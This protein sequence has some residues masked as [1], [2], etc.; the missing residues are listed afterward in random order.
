MKKNEPFYTNV[1]VQGNQVYHFYI[2]ENGKRKKEQVRFEPTLAVRTNTKT[3]Y[4]DIHGNYLQ[5]KTFGNNMQMWGWKKKKQDYEEIF[6]DIGVPYEF[7][8]RTYPNDIGVPDLS[9]LKIFNIDIETDSGINGEFPSA[10]EAKYHI[11]LITIHD[12]N[13]DKFYTFGHTFDYTP[14]DKRVVYWKYDNEREMM[15][16]FLH[17]F[18]KQRPDVVTGW[19]IEGYD[20]PYIVNRIEHILPENE[21]P[22]LLSPVNELEEFKT[23]MNNQS[24][25]IKGIAIMDYMKAYKKLELKPIEN[26]KLDTVAR[27]EKVMHKL[28]YEGSLAELYRENF[29]LYVDY[30]I[31]DTEV[32]SAIDKKK[33]F[34]TVLFTLSYMGKVNFEDSF[35]SV[36]IWD[37]LIYN[38]FLKK[39]IL[40]PP[41]KFNSRQQFPGGYVKEPIPGLYPWLMVED[42]TSS[43]PNQIISGNISPE[44]IIDAG[45]LPDELFEIHERFKQIDWLSGDGFIDIDTE[46][47]NVTS[48]LKKHNMSMLANGEFFTT[49][50]YGLFPITVDGIFQGRKQKKEEAKVLK[51]KLNNLKNERE[52]LLKKLE[53]YK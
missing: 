22:I 36:K 10:E 48:L 49:E 16:A 24:Y 8:G 47:E 13:K 45:D 25:R 23:E 32:V 2:D 28:E 30:N 41:K 14:E 21:S 11:T 12:M 33:K 42:I 19:N 17:W 18:R 7:I 9:L 1:V 37:C 53:R 6:G 52:D 51:E 4:T 38:V 50:K 46:L 31:K 29:K 20:I 43:Y 5:V 15:S 44:T 35:G 27:H 3:P 40:V 26:Y 34:L 39:N